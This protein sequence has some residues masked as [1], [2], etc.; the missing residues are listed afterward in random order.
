VVG[1][2]VVFSIV[3]AVVGCRSRR[4]FAGFFESTYD[5]CV[6]VAQVVAW[7]LVV[8]DCVVWVHVVCCVVGGA[9]GFSVR[10]AAGCS[11]IN[12]L[13]LLVLGLLVSVPV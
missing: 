9:V 4:L 8:F 13:Q 7:G 11:C 2:L 5:A 3:G 1:I 12:L 6:I 10:H